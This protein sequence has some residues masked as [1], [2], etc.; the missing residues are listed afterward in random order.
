[1]SIP[2]A[3]VTILDVARVAG[4][5]RQ[6]VTRALND[7]ADVSAATKARVIAAAGELNYR[8]NRAAQSMVRGRRTTI[9]LVLEDLRNPYFAELAAAVNSAAADRDW[10]VLL[11]DV[12]TDRGKTR[13][14]LASITSSVDALV[15]TGCRTDTLSL[16]PDDVLRGGQ[17]RLPLVMIDG[18]ADERLNGRVVL[19]VEEGV[20]A[21]IDRLVSQ[22]RRRIAFLG[23]DVG[24]DVRRD[25]YRASVQEQGLSWEDLP[26]LIAEE[27]VEGGMRAA[28]ELL[29]QCPDVD[30]VLVYNDVMALGVLKALARAG[31]QV[32]EEVA[33]IGMDGLDVGRLVTPELTTLSIDK[34]QLADAAVALLEK[35]FAGIPITGADET[36]V[37]LTLL[38]RD[39]A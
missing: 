14:Q 16:L 39:S 32:P 20:R 38:V 7:M 23:S 28:D 21:A 9:G 1:M 10:G 35:S 4:V 15:L 2:P 29:Q 17:R 5:S 36:S 33:V 11:C 25:V 18:P 34:A 22:N 37:G 27:S 12:G 24:T 19:E 3:P 8:P 26:A 13:G 30:A 31:R 6:T